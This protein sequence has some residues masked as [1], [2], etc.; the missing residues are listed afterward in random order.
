M[1][2]TAYMMEI[3]C[4]EGRLYWKSGNRWFL[5]DP[6]F[7]PIVPEH[8]APEGS[9][10]EE[11]YQFADEYVQALDEG[12]E[13]ECSGEAGRQVMEILMDIFESGA[14]RHRVEVPQKDRSHPLLRWREQAGLAL[15][16]AMPGPCGEWLEAED[17]RL[18]RVSLLA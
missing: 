5:P 3:Y 1:D 6:H 16:A 9:A 4:S 15:P 14:Y 11:D 18:G 2:T 12:R 10:S 7:A 13:H 8:Y 17:R